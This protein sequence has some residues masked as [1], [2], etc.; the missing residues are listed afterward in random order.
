LGGRQPIC[1]F[2]AKVEWRPFV[3][4]NCMVEGNVSAGGCVPLM[5]EERFW[6]CGSEQNRKLAKEIN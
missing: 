5:V 2:K 4:Q 3:E 6:N 1:V